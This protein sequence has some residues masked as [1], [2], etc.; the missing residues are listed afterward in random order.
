MLVVA[1]SVTLLFG[2]VS[3][4][5]VPV[6]LTAQPAFGA[7]CPCSLWDNATTPASTTVHN[8]GSPIEVGAKFRSDLAG[9][10]TALRFY[11][12]PGTTGT[13]TGHLWALD[14]T[15]LATQVFATESS[16]GWQQVALDSPVTI[17][18]NTTYVVSV[19]SSSG[20][21]VSDH[22]YFTAAHDNPPLHG[23]ADGTDGGNGVFNQGSS[24]FPMTSFDA[25]NYWTDVVF[26]EPDT[27]P[28]AISQLT[29]HPVSTTT[30]SVSWV[31]DEPAT[32]RVDYG[33]S[34]SSLS[35]SVSDSALTTSHSLTLTG[36]TP[37]TSYFLRATSTDTSNNS[38]TSP[39][40]TDPPESFTTPAFAATDTAA[41]DFDAGTGCSV[42]EHETGPASGEV[43]L[44][45][46]R[47]NEFND[48]ALPADWQ[49][50]AFD[51]SGTATVGGGALAADGAFASTT[52]VSTPG[53]SLEFAA[54]FQAEPFQHVGFTV[55]FQQPFW[56]IFSTG[57]AGT[58]LLARTDNNGSVQDDLIPGNWLGTQHRFRIDWLASTVVFSIDGNVVDTQNVAITQ[59]L[60]VGVSDLTVSPKQVSVDWLQ[61][62]PF[63]ASC[64]FVSRAIDAGAN[65]DWSTLDAQANL[66]TGTSV[67]VETRTSNDATHWSPFA[68][69]TGNTIQSPNGHFLQ[70][71]ATVSTTDDTVTPVVQ[72]V[73]IVAA[74]QPADQT[75]PT[76]S[77]VLP[78]NNAWIHAPRTLVASA[79]DDVGVTSV[80]FHAS[81][82]GL[83][84]NELVGT[85]TLTVFGWVSSWTKTGLPDLAAYS[86]WSQAFD[87]AGNSSTST[88]ITVMVDNT[89]PT[90]SMLVPSNNSAAKGVVALDAAASDNQKVVRV[91]FRATGPGLANDALIGTG[92]VSLYGWIGSWNTSGRNGTYTVSSVAFDT[93]GNSTRSATITVKVDN[94]PPSTSM[95]MPS[96][97]ASVHGNATLDAK[98]TDNVGVTKV[99]FHATGP[100][101]ANDA[102]VGTGALSPY[103]WI[104][105]WNTSGRNGTYTLSSIAFDAAGN[106]T[107]SSTITIIVSN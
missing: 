66:P 48:S 70:Y 73:S 103:G 85:G 49:V 81:G 102:L 39:V 71:R 22:P 75:P 46:N 30:Q 101:L 88:P 11:K 106:S 52:A 10:I 12:G 43:Q 95:L 14:G 16:S 20:D 6:G 33:T 91:E 100:G 45:A 84:P 62:T 23:L 78:P 44:S 40:A 60:R 90:T 72:S 53:R 32:S 5:P 4:L 86:L 79:S 24:A 2:T 31:T 36:L 68:A 37:T 58:G 34:A 61:M 94:A 3:A 9:S 38:A 82:P 107:R 63:D 83:V 35:T 47:D 54:T 21:Y 67:S 13:H 87:A 69:V 1:T 89:A 76:T 29:A 27:A 28:P 80:E 8:E 55:D 99:E 104:G 93:A 15:P 26:A 41:A 51:P 65:V 7:S 77:V 56:A 42:V 74:R 59:S 17:S 96:N 57:S 19:F 105:S 97:H 64:S 18:A 98:A 25:S 92:T 50:S